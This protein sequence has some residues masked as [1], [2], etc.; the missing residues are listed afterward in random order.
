[1]FEFFHARVTVGMPDI[2][3]FLDTTAVR[4]E[5]QDLVCILR[6]WI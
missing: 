5:T 3:S 4:D 1:L 6:K 2:S